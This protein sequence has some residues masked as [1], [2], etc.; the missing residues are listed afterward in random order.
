MVQ[1]RRVDLDF[2]CVPYPHSVLNVIQNTAEN[3]LRIYAYPGP[4]LHTPT[5]VGV[6][7]VNF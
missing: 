6:P 3:L 2:K 7:A 5:T 1:I 4:P